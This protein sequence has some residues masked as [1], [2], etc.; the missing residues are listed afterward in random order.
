MVFASKVQ[1]IYLLHLCIET[2]KPVTI[3]HSRNL[4]L[5]VYD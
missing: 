5:K 3:D 2:N 4:T 1:N